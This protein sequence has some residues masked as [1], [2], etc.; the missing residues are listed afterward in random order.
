M[1]G[2]FER[3]LDHFQAAITLEP[4][5]HMVGIGEIGLE[6]SF[7]LSA[8]ASLKIASSLT[9]ITSTNRSIFFLVVDGRGRS[10]NQGPLSCSSSVRSRATRAVASFSTKPIPSTCLSIPLTCSSNRA[11]SASN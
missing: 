7:S 9:S 5:T 4:K 10:F 2:V 6:I 3:L 11:G 1:P 8:S